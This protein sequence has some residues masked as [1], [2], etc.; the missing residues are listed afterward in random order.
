[1]STHIDQVDNPSERQ[2]AVIIFERRD[3]LEVPSRGRGLHPS[4]Q[5]ALERS[6]TYFEPVFACRPIE[7]GDLVC[8]TARHMVVS[9]SCFRII[10]R[11]QVDDLQ[12]HMCV[13]RLLPGE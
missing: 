9:E 12:W 1:M 8:V 3:T 4:A 10:T 2:L 11:E 6:Q 5:V 13:Y 7:N